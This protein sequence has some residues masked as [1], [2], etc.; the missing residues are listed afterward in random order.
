MARIE[1]E[2]NSL[3]SL[4]SR[5]RVQNGRV[6]FYLSLVFFLI[7]AVSLIATFLFTFFAVFDCGLVVALEI[8]LIFSLISFG[9]RTVWR[10]F[11]R[12]MKTSLIN[13]GDI[14]MKINS[15]PVKIVQH[16]V[17]ITGDDVTIEGKVIPDGWGASYM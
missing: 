2:D 11:M 14:S 12:L 7:Y 13:S 15:V 6:Y 16:R 5:Y 1:I 9:I 3:W 17:N 8:L 4:Y 10:A